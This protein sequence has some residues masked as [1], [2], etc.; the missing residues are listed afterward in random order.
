MPNE[1]FELIITG[2]LDVTR[3]ALDIEEEV[4]SNERGNGDGGAGEQAAKHAV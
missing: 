1:R 3:P 2:E 4:S